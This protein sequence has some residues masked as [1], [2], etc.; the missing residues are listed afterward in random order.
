MDI[1]H[2]KELCLNNFEI[3]LWFAILRFKD[4]IS[5]NVAMLSMEFLMGLEKNYIIQ[6]ITT[7]YGLELYIS[8]CHVKF[9]QILL[10]C[11]H[12]THKQQSKPKSGCVSETKF[13]RLKSTEVAQ[14]WFTENFWT[15]KIT[16]AQRI[17]LNIPVN[18][19]KGQHTLN[20]YFTPDT[21]IS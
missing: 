17:L 19:N 9:S 7:L 10:C 5:I 18:N 1:R 8:H 3:S 21:Y 4:S 14:F 12:K 16:E 6:L 2:Y 11:L 20:A 15:W 13:S